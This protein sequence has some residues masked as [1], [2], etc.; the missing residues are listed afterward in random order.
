LVEPHTADTADDVLAR[1]RNGQSH[2]TVNSS[3][4]G[5]LAAAERNLLLEDMPLQGDDICYTIRSYVVAR[6]SKDSD[7][8]HPVKSSTCLPGSRYHLKTAVAHSRDENR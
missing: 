4:R 3:G 5:M 2:F 1:L 7:S 6:D 8:T